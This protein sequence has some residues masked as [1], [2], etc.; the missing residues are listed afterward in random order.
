[1]EQL[2]MSI[3]DELER[4]WDFFQ[5]H[6]HLAKFLG[7]GIKISIVV[8]AVK[9]IG[10]ILGKNIARF[11]ALRKA[12][13]LKVKMSDQREK[14]LVKMIENSIAYILKFAALV[15][16]LT[17]LGVDTTALAISAGFIGV[18]AGMGAQTVIR[19]VI[20]GFFIIFE[21]Q[22][23]VGDR[24]RINANVLIEGTVQVIGLRT[25]KI[26]ADAGEEIIVPNGSILQ[27]AIL[28][29]NEDEEAKPVRVAE[30][31]NRKAGYKITR[32]KKDVIRKKRRR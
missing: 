26:L 24:V 8:V 32:S 14:T 11:F 25:T 4:I 12:T 18:V 7:V 28:D 17:I 23:S 10:K 20:V 16:I 13:P 21:D 9:I 27:V 5:N 3:S 22:F 15:L 19:D 30:I 31:K 2:L 6:Q 1:M 29:E